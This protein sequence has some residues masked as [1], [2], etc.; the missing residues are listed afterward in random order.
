MLGLILFS[1]MVSGI[2]AYPYCKYH[3][4]NTIDIDCDVSK[5]MSARLEWRAFDSRTNT[6]LT[7]YRCTNADDCGIAVPFL[8]GSVGFDSVSES[9]MIS[10]SGMEI[11]EIAQYYNVYSQFQCW[12][13]DNLTLVCDTPDML[14][15]VINPTCSTPVISDNI[16]VN[17][18]C[19][20]AT[21]FKPNDYNFTILTNKRNRNITTAAIDYSEHYS[22]MDIQ[23]VRYYDVN[24][25]L[26]TDLSRL[27]SGY[28]KFSVAVNHK[29]FRSSIASTVLNVTSKINVP[30]CDLPRLSNDSTRLDL[31]CRTNLVY[32]QLQCDFNTWTNKM[33]RN[34]SGEVNYSTS[35]ALSST[36]IGYLSE[37][38]MNV[39]IS[40][41]GPGSHEFQVTMSTN[42]SSN[43]TVTGQ[44]TP[45]FQ[46]GLPTVRLSDECVHKAN[47]LHGKVW[48]NFTCLCLLDSPGMP[49]GSLV[50]SVNNVVRP[51]AA[52]T[53]FFSDV[54]NK[55][56]YVCIPET[57][58]QA[59]ISGV[60]LII[61]VPRTPSIVSFTANSSSEDTAINLNDHLSF[62]CDA[63]GL[64]SPTILF[65][66]N[67]GQ[68]TTINGSNPL[69]MQFNS[70]LNTGQYCCT[71]ENST[72][73]KVESKCLSVFVRC[74]QVLENTTHTTIIARQGDKV[75]LTISVYGYP[76][77]N[78]FVLSKTAGT[79]REVISPSRYLVTYTE[80]TS[81]YG[82]IL[83]EMSIRQAGDFANYML[84]VGNGVGDKQNAY[85]SVIKE[86]T[87][88][89]GSGSKIRD[90]EMGV[91]CGA[92]AVIILIV[93][94]I[95]LV[96]KG[97][98]KHKE[99]NK[100]SELNKLSENS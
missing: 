82:S 68:E 39:N 96:K 88:N 83:L 80:L 62:R 29:N 9:L 12:G 27:R 3:R 100:D 42:S 32:P 56:K 52:V 41:I 18:V 90:L 44:V 30:N 47:S 89:S 71:V 23:E 19:R 72:S 64:P 46:L 69:P 1:V 67:H 79:G 61:S 26:E 70:C 22:P 63:D 33:V 73:Y 24:F 55:V 40:Q 7:I 17:I 28:H 45:P 77:P 38:Q 97:L 51:E 85:F 35:L 91:S 5:L 13:G 78:E 58:L 49:S 48:S 4:S 2:E 20:A 34:V 43:A 54:V 31:R 57:P 37:C 15:A 87:H 11:P 92:L 60:E 94:V 21:F 84:S 25:T 76:T 10:S 81:P 95:V 59:N 93:V 86:R 16:N 98:C 50:W 66:K 75:N 36:P 99:M 6:S 74:P 53:A 8:N 65:G 14:A